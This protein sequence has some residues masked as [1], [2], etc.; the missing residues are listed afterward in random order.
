VVALQRTVLAL[1]SGDAGTIF[2]GSPAA[3]DASPAVA[4]LSPTR[5]ILTDADP[6]YGAPDLGTLVHEA[7]RKNTEKH[8]QQKSALLKTQYMS[9]V[10]A[11]FHFLEPEEGTPP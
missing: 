3:A 2:D 4:A 1:I 8:A 10:A 9:A 5:T 7:T 11:R 6:R